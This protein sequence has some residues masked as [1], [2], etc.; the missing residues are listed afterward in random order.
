VI[1]AMTTSARIGRHQA[2]STGAIWHWAPLT[3]H[4]PGARTAPI[5]RGAQRAGV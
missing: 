4:W 3:Y 1:G 5:L 2:R